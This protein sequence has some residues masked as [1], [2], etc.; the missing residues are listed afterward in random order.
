MF[1]LN[2]GVHQYFF[3]QQDGLRKPRKFRTDA[4]EARTGKPSAYLPK[5]YAVGLSGV[6][7]VA[8]GGGRF[9]YRY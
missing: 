4:L 1:F 9:F 8:A 5:D 7:I 3:L 2:F 6:V